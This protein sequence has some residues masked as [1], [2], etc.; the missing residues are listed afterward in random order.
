MIIGYRQ[1]EVQEEEGSEITDNLSG[2]W[3]GWGGRG[4]G[5]GREQT[6]AVR[7]SF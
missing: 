3:G 5:V 6:C 1:E 7:A 4:R 2:G